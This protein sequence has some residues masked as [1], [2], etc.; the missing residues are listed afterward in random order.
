MG[1]KFFAWPEAPRYSYGIHTCVVGSEHINIRVAHIENLFGPL[2]TYHL[3]NI[4]HDFGRRFYGYPFTVAENGTKRSGGEVVSHKG[5][6]CLM[7]FVAGH[8][9]CYT[10]PV[11]F[12]KQFNNAIIWCRK[13]GLM[14]LIVGEE[15]LS[16]LCN[17]LLCSL[18]WWQC[19]LKEFHYAAANHK[20]IGLT[21]VGG[22][23]NEPQCVVDSLGNITNGIKQSAVEVEYDKL[24]VHNKQFPLLPHK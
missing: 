6:G 22:K 8:G 15:V 3:H 7:I 10:S 14:R 4:P 19:S 12:S 21:L 5:F 18:L 9:E 11:K 24:F 13:V 17:V 23:T 2:N 20:T 1:G 16:Y